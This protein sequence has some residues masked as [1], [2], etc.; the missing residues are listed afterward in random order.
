MAEQRGT[1]PAVGEL[2]TV[3]LAVT[4]VVS[5]SYDQAYELAKKEFCDYFGERPFAIQGSKAN[6]RDDGLAEVQFVAVM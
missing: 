6:M 4:T 5:V 2:P 1:T 3:H